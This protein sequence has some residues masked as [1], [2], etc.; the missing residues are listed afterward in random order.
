MELITISTLALSNMKNAEHVQYHTN[1]RDILVKVTAEVIGLNVQVMNAY[2]PAI[3][4]EQ[5]IVNMASGSAFTTQMKEL[6]QKRDTIFRRVRRKLELCEVEDTASV[7]YKARETVKKQLLSK[8]P[9]TVCSLAYQEETATITGFVQDCRSAL[10]AEQL[11]GI[12]IDADLDDLLAVNQKFSEVYQKRVDEK[13]SVDSQ[14]SLKLRATTDQA[15]AVLVFN[16]NTV[17]NDPT[18]ANKEKVEAARATVQKI[19]VLIK[20]AKTRM[21]QRKNGLSEEDEAADG[22]NG[23]SGSNSGSGSG[24]GSGTGNGSG[25]GSGNGNSS[26]SGSGTGSGSGSNNNVME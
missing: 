20:E 16:L 23:G 15:Y 6:D 7:A 26:G 9:Q 8:Y 22:D 11:E 4:A 5:D 21:E 19:N 2:T 12:R 10:T 13:A 24:N 17:A 18:P 14:L 25:S 3:E 1:V